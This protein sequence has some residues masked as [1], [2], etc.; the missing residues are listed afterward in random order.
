MTE[1]TKHSI[2]LLLIAL[3]ALPFFVIITAPTW[4]VSTLELQSEALYF[5]S[6]FGY[7][8]VALLVWE[9]ALGTR[10]ISGLYFLDLVSKLRLHRWLGTYGVLLIFLH[11]L[12]VIYALNQSYW[13]TV[14][15]NV[16]SGYELHV[17]YGRIAFIGLLVIWLTSAIIRGKIAY[18]PWKYIHYIS[19]PILVFSLLHVPAIGPSINYVW[20]HFFWLF[21]CVVAT[22]CFALRAAHFFGYGKLAYRIKESVMIAPDIFYLKMV[23]LERGVG[24]RTGQ[25]VYVQS[26]V[27]GEEHPFSVLDHDAKTGEFSIAFK[28]FGKFT[29]GLST[30]PVGD[31]LMV[32]GPYGTFTHEIDINPNRTSVFIAGGI[33]IT[34]FV[35]HAISRPKQSYL[36]AAN[37]TRQTAI[38]RTLLRE[39][40]G[41]R[42]IEA[43]SREPKETAVA[44]QEIGRL[45]ASV[46]QKYLPNP[47]ECDYYI[48]GPQSMMDAAKEALLSLGVPQRNIRAE[49]FG[50]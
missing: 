47:A 21:F 5:S 50:F 25:Y 15:P 9:L 17:T 34:P 3:S 26:R 36:F 24:I 8:G 38:F 32:D 39:K 28:V 49:E 22:I 30:I 20:V 12:L 16:S 6:V 4:G 23:P 48:C 18:R 41:E 2:L 44:N 33:G 29:Q 19:Y 7:I 10:S 14:V 43:F 31:T 40:L 11:P 27:Y 42:F 37:Q 13:Y 46:F 45:D 1:R 35:K